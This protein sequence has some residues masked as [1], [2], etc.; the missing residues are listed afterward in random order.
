MWTIDLEVPT[1]TTKTINLEKL[2]ARSAQ[3]KNEKNN[4]GRQPDSVRKIS[5]SQNELENNVK[6]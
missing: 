3:R 2:V 1:T 5:N 6:Q 4:L